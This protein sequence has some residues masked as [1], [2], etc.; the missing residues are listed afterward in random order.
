LSK[1][2]RPLGDKFH[3]IGE[4]QEK[5]YRQRYLD[6]IF[7]IETLHRMKFR[8]NFIK[9]LR[10]FYRSHDFVE[11][12]CPV[13]I[14]SASGAAAKPFV[15]HHHDFDMD[16]YLRICNEIELKKATVG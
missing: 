14:P 3:G 11:I 2:L 10:K 1:A 7:N 8:S 15:T 6:M 12:D 5:S 4:D 13:L 9:T 16:F